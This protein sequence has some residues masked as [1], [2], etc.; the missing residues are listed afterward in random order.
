MA[1]TDNTYSTCINEAKQYNTQSP[2]V[3]QTYTCTHVCTL[4][5]ISITV[6]RTCTL[7]FMHCGRYR[8]T[9]H[10]LTITVVGT[11]FRTKLTKSEDCRAPNMMESGFPYIL[12]V[13]ENEIPMFFGQTLI[14][15]FS[16]YTHLLQLSSHRILH[17]YRQHVH[18]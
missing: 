4:H 12:L 8:C 7:I 18:V 17:V 3:L 1:N 11:T 5:T 2:T 15:R 16:I 10:A 13:V 14:F 9:L 6:V